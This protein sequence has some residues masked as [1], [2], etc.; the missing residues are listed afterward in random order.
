MTIYLYVKQHHLT[1]LKYL[2]KTTKSDPHTYTG[3][4]IRWL[5][6]LN[7]HGYNYTTTILRECQDNDELKY[8][9]KYYSDLWDIVESNNWANLKT[10]E[11][12]GG[13]LG[14]DSRAKLSK[15]KTGILKTAEHKQNI[16]RSK[17][18]Q[19]Y[20]SQT[21]T[22]KLNNGLSKKGRPQPKDAIERRTQSRAGRKWYNNGQKSLLATNCPDGF[23]PG[24]LS[25][26]CKGRAPNTR[27]FTNGELNIIATECPL[28][29]YPGMAKTQHKA[30]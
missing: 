14:K 4:G 8:W 7:K 13:S 12:Q 29:F 28:G 21:E 18:G 30:K 15:T 10:E 25:G 2:G 24:R 5:N 22:H 9:G 11:G 26:D 20:G 23:R 19:K 17:T 27:W 3:S 1:G 16:S 6:H